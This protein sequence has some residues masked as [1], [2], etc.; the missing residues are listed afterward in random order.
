MQK[1]IS[2]GQLMANMAFNFSQNYSTDKDETMLELSGYAYNFKQLSKDWDE[3][4]IIYINSLE[5]KK[6]QEP[7][8]DVGFEVF[9]MIPKF[10]E[11][12]DKAQAGSMAELD[13]IHKFAKDVDKAA[14]FCYTGSI[15]EKG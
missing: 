12:W 14:K 1:L 3:A 5:D 8:W 4:I 15:E 9:K 2:V 6:D 7:V 13:L 11:D 10:L